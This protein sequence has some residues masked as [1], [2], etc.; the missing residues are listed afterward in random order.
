MP[1]LGGPGAPGRG[2]RWHPCTADRRANPAGKLYISPDTVKTHL[3][4]IYQKL[5]ATDRTAAVAE[6]LRRRLIE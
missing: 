1:S 6:A 2:E 3:E 5:G 4:H